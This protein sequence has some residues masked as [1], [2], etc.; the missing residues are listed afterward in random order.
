MCEEMIL[1]NMQV[2]AGRLCIMLAVVAVT[3]LCFFYRHFVGKLFISCWYET[4]HYV[5][6]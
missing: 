5:Y 2:V 4:W 6:V 3:F 1:A